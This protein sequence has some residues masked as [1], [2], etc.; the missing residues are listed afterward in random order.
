[1]SRRNVARFVGAAAAC[2]LTGLWAHGA[3]AA[4]VILD[5][6]EPAF[7]VTNPP[8]DPHTGNPLNSSPPWSSHGRVVTSSKGVGITAVNSG[9]SFDFAVIFDTRRLNTSDPDL[10]D[11]FGA[12]TGAGS[13]GIST[14][15]TASDGL[16]RPGHVLIV[17]EN[18]NPANCNGGT[19]CGDPDDEADGTNRLEFTFAQSEFAGGVS[20]ESIDIMDI[21][22]NEYAKL[23]I[24]DQQNV[25][26][27]GPVQ[28]NGSQVGDHNIARLDLQ[29]FFQ[30]NAGVGKF[31]V[32]LKSSGA[33]TNLAFNYN[34]N[35]GGQVPE[36]ASLG[37][38][39]AGLVGLGAFA[40]RRRPRR[41][42]A[43][44]R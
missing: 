13:P 31:V 41:D 8:D 22:S 14:P 6:N 40:R 38:L 28:I 4:L 17:Q 37:L 3:S 23:Y 5:F 32:E 25:Q 43:R 18:N 20:L 11:W 42:A 29:H 9:E 12:A 34:G 35:N 30:G 2:L 10:E 44:Y 16:L 33:V 21:D 26:I 15:P 1:V 36:P 24:Y 39:A 7:E 19:T 27:G